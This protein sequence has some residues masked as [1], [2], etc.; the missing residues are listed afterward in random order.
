M[1][2]SGWLYRSY[3]QQQKHLQ[4]IAATK[5][6]MLTL[7]AYELLYLCPMN[8][9]Y[10]QLLP[11]E[12][13]ANS[14]VWIY[15]SNRLFSVREALQIE[16]IL[17]SFVTSWKSHGTPVKGFA[18]LFFGQF[19]VLM[20][21]E[22]ATGVS[23]CSTDSSVRM[24]KLIEETFQVQ[25]FNRQLLAFVIKDKIEVLP[26]QQLSYAWEHG[27]I[28]AHTLYFNNLVDTKEA[29]EQR[30]IVPVRQ[31]WLAQ[32]LPLAPANPS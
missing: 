25:L 30:W 26:L 10:T 13:D 18:T 23:G 24:V 16:E 3:E 22:R 12:F 21:D 11:A 32:K 29:L 19:V 20:A 27:F 4:P 9:Q 6:G 14:R 15:Q 8:L 31:S 5:S 2:Q 1:K 28:D 7:V 17:E